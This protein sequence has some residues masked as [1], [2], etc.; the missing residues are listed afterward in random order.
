IRLAQLHV[1]RSPG[2]GQMVDLETV[3]ST[4]L[5][6][7]RTFR[8]IN[9]AIDPWQGV[10]LTQGIR[11]RGVACEL[12]PFTKHNLMSM[13]TLTLEAFRLRKIELFECDQL[14]SHL[15]QLRVRDSEQGVRLDSPQG[16]SDHG[17]CATSLALACHAARGIQS[18]VAPQFHG[19]LITSADPGGDYGR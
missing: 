14:K 7:H 19:T 15:E 10:D 9:I 4:V 17:D 5:D 12:V 6:A 16:K 1:W 13:A 8:M 18:Y 3:R 2:P 11:K